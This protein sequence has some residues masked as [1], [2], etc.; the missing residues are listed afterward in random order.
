MSNLGYIVMASDDVIEMC[1]RTIKLI[2]KEREKRIERYR[3]YKTFFGRTIVRTDAE[4]KAM[5]NTIPAT[6]DFYYSESLL[7]DVEQ[8]TEAANLTSS[9]IVSVDLL[10]NIKRLYEYLV[11]KENKNA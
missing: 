3:T 8:M 6:W 1:D 9:V 7:R 4:L 5:S 2:M 10:G 11:S